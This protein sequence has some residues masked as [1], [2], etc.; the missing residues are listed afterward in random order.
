MKKILKPYLIRGVYQWIVDN[1]ET[2][3]LVVQVDQN[4]RVPEGYARD[5]E[6]TLNISMNATQNL[7][8]GIDAIAFDTRFNTRVWSCWIPINTVVGLYS[9]E[10]GQ[11]MQFS[12][13]EEPT[14][15]QP[16]NDHQQS[17]EQTPPQPSSVPPRPP[18]GKPNL[19]LIKS[20]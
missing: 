16:S 1:N 15:Q 13:N 14:A 10:S 2:P 3:Y 7:D 20:D 11:G 17:N 12:Y 5:G 8:L 18:K 19:K 4:T 9:R 6:I